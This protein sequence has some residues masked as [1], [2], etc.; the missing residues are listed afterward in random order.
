MLNKTQEGM[1][2][3]LVNEIA[4]G[5]DLDTIKDNSHEWID[6]WIPVYNN[7]IIEEWQN[8]PSEYDNR[9]ANELGYNDSELDIVRLMSLDLY[10][11]YTDLFN[12]V[13][14]EMEE[15]IAHD[16]EEVSA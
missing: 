6:G 10:L 8:M 2:E 7:R 14:E 3:E 4:Q 15:D 13:I 12:E 9:G 16:T 5:S 1:K 11:Y